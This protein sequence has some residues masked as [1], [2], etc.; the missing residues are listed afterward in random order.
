MTSFVRRSTALFGLLGPLLTLACSTEES[1]TYATPSASASTGAGG[2]GGQGAGGAGGGVA[3][4]TG[5][6]REGGEC[7]ATLTAWAAGPLLNH[8]RDHHVS[9]VADTAA[10]PFFYVAAGMG[11]IA[12]RK[13][14]ERAPILEDG[15]LGAF[16]DIGDLPESLVGPGLAQGEHTF[17][18]VGGLANDGNSLATTYVGTIGEDGS[19]TVT[20]GPAMA[21]D[22]YHVGV[23][24]VNGYL[25][26]LGGLQ[27]DVT[28]GSVVQD[29]LDV[30]ERAA[31]DGT[32]L[33][34][35]ET[36]APLPDALT[37]HAVFAHDGALYVVGG[38]KGVAAGTDILRATVS[39]EGELGAWETVGQLP[40][41]RA[42]SAAFVWLGQ[43]YVVAGMTSLVGNEK[44]TVLR[45]PVDA[46]GAIGAFEE[47]P[48]LPLAR[49]HCH[50][51][52]RWGA[53][54]FSAGGSI[55]HEPQREVFVGAFE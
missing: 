36:M 54:L 49:A 26:A 40:E 37:H 6:H 50:Q 28:G 22:R 46:A 3:C 29:V 9:F 8:S 34:A 23:A 44:P 24:T 35:F 7:V 5:S 15:S 47:L 17:V 55:D 52:P 51:A 18:L 30:V 4:E 38:G 41:G 39:A 10:G 25:F 1:I 16:E 20:P 13:P 14:I 53:S 48:A 2:S 19:V 21:E 27:Q 12:P 45:A 33:S 43:V 32:T 31:F 11:T 42:T